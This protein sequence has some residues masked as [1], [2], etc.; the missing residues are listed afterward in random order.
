MSR[1]RYSY[2]P[3]QSHARPAMQRAI[4][5]LLLI[6]ALTLLVLSRSQHPTV[7]HLRMSMLEMLRPLMEVVSQ[8]VSATKRAAD[9]TSAVF[10]AAEENRV[11]R[12]ENERLRHWQS[13]AQALK[14]ENE[15]L[16]AL[17][18]YHPVEQVSYVTA[19]VIGQSSSGFGQYLTLNAGSADGLEPLQPVVDMYGLVGRTLEVGSHTSTVMQLS[20]V[21]SRVPVITASTRQRA[22]LAGTGGELLRLSFL[23][24]DVELKLGE[25]IVTTQEGNLIPGGIAVGS[26]FRRD[27]NGYLVKPMRSLSQSEYLRVIQTAAQPQRSNTAATPAGGA[28][29]ATLY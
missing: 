24:D 4:V 29:P 5:A 16:R 18:R 10:N 17:M 19:R 27:N 11:L 25:P 9:N 20:D 1:D 21:G 12:A 7:Q 14:A 22:I 3:A 13:V 23:G 15:S 26:I 2:S 28:A 8:P 6:T